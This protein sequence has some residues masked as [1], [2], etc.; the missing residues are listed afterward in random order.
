[1]SLVSRNLGISGESHAVNYLQKKGYMIRARNERTKFGEIDIIAER[2]HKIVFIEVKTRSSLEKGKPYESVT[3]G[4]QKRLLRAAQ[5]YIL[6]NR[7]SAYKLSI[8]VI[9][10]IVN[11]SGK[12]NTIDF[13]ED[14][15]SY[16]L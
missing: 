9:S 15:G 14:I 8:G 6:K 5:Y 4:K 2:N 7:L 1:M 16:D 3:Y 10:I 12:K 11:S 13:F